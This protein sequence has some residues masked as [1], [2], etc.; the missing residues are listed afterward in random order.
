MEELVLFFMSFVVIFIIYQV[1][2][3]RKSKKGNFDK[4]PTE[5]IYIKKKYDINVDKS[6]YMKILNM[7][8]LVSAF[9]ISLVVSISFLVNNFLLRM[10]VIIILSPLLFIITYH[11]VGKHFKME[12]K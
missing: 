2:V 7:V 12:G 3:I 11:L 10:L 5:V 1:F 9:D 6:N 8:A 4:L